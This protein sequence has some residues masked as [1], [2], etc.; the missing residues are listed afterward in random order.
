[1]SETNGRTL[2][3]GPAALGAL[4]WVTLVLAAYYW[5]HKPLT[6]ALAR[7]LGG[8]ALDVVSAAALV[9]LG[10]GVGRALLRRVDVSFW[11]VPE[12]LA[13]QALIGLGALALLMLAVGIV[14]LHPLGV[15]ALL[16]ALTVGAR[17]DVR[18]WGRE[19]AAWVRTARVEGA[20]AR[21]LAVYV[22]GMVAL[23]LPLALLPPTKWD[24][25]TYHLVGPQRYLAHGRI[26]AVPHNHFLGFPQL[27][28]MLYTAQLALTGQLSGAAVLHGSVGVL[29]LMAAG[30]YAARR[31]GQV[32][33]WLA[34]ALL[35]SAPSIW[36]ELT[37]AY[38]DLL[39]IAVAVLALG[40]LERS[41]EVE[42]GRAPIA[43]AGALTGLALGTK[44]SA[45]WL[46]LALGLLVL[47]LGGAARRLAGGFAR[48]T[49]LRG[50]GG[51]GLCAL[52][53]A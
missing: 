39:P 7:T 12:R 21:G 40:A 28:E 31:G 24:V 13:A 47:V 18:A 41:A 53:A 2:R 33:G 45:L 11:S 22:L 26:Y 10:G 38:V 4:L 34:A 49:D 27:L 29:A 17:R 1:M 32:A 15:A 35:L 9:A 52:A 44:Y 25:L 48:R 6:P 16:I 30:G 46:A 5:A 51:R 36:W 50:S 23:A 14:W 3:H 37:F 19:F 43:L 20:W 8:A 42:D